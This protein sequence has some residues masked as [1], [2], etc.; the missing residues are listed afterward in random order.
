MDKSYEKVAYGI[1]STALD[2][3]VTAGSIRE[4]LPQAWKFHLQGFN[5]D[6]RAREVLKDLPRQA[7]DAWA[8]LC[9]VA[10]NIETG[11]GYCRFRS[12]IP[13]EHIESAGW[14]FIALHRAVQ[15]RCMP[16]AATYAHWIN[17]HADRA[18][19]MAHSEALSEV[20]R[21]RLESWKLEPGSRPN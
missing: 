5:F 17:E 11:P 21:E 19:T 9:E 15:L 7:M 2:V 20:L 4:G 10:R 8:L 18:M 13:P 1:V 16:A 3:I 14:A 12:G 6:D